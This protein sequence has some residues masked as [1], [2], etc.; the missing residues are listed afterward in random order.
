MKGDGQV[1]QV[2]SATSLQLQVKLATFHQMRVKS[3]TNP[4]RNNL[5]SVTSFLTC[6]FSKIII[7]HIA[8]MALIRTGSIEV[9]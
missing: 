6:S 3:G 4:V 8:M 5:H 2:K 1:L 9:C 7:S